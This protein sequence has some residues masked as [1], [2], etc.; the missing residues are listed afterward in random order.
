MDDTINHISP[1]MQADSSHPRRVERVR[2][3]LVLRDLTVSR[4][5]RLSPGFI[6]ITF[7]ND[8]LDSFVSLAF[9]DHLKF[10]V[11]DT[12]AV[13]QRRDFTPRSFDQ[14]RRELTL[15][16]ALHQ[17]GP[18]SDW[19]RRAK[20]GDIARVGGPRGSM[21]IPNDYDWYLLVGDA[22]ALPAIHRRLEEL[23]NGTKSIAHILVEESADQR[24]F[25]S[26]TNLRVTWVKSEAAL[27]ASLREMVL[28]AGSGFVWAAGE[29]A[30]ISQLRDVVLKEKEIP[31]SDTR[32]SA[33]WKR[34]AAD[35]HEEKTRPPL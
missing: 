24:T 11:D 10:M 4:I 26:Q 29:A 12:Q 18:A 14:Q 15:E 5:D 20:I 16:F 8:S 6:S 21:I 28:P 9:D 2:H 35:F 13:T 22:S 32:I 3:D 1:F 23:P 30:L 33:Y 27:I 17:R 7:T 19:A 25:A 31:L 34:G